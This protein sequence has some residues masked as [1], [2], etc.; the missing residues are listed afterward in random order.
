M[1]DFCG[2]DLRIGDKVIVALPDYQ[3]LANATIIQF[4]ER[5]VV[6]EF[7]ND[8]YHIGNFMQNCVVKPYHL[9]KVK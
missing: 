3:G 7:I 5:E 1:K 9:S 4:T 6:V 2:N 8:W